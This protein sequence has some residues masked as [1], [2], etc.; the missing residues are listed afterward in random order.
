MT[1][2]R[3]ISPLI[4]ETASKAILDRFAGSVLTIPSHIYGDHPLAALGEVATV[5]SYH[6][7]GYKV[8][9]PMGR[10]QALVD[11]NQMLY[12][13]RDQGFTAAKLASK[14]GLSERAVWKI[15]R[16]RRNNY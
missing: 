4:G 6:Y 1:S 2:F 13:D 7:G 10:S 14:Y 11:R 9:I 8:Y 3:E 5:L 15:L 12:A 16:N